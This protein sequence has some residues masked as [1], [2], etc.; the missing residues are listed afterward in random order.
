M[1]RTRLILA[2]ILKDPGCNLQVVLI[3]SSLAICFYE[4]KS[5]ILT[6]KFLDKESLRQWFPQSA[7]LIH[8]E[9]VL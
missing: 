1:I 3:Q 4:P 2:S 8:A 5:L 9:N 7:K 6:R